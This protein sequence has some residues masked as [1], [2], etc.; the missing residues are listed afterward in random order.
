MKRKFAVLRVAAL[1]TLASCGGLPVSNAQYSVGYAPGEV[2]PNNAVPTF[3]MGN[4][5]S[6]PQPEFAAAVVDAMQGNTSDPATFV[7]SNNSSGVYRVIM[8]FGSGTFTGGALCAQPPR[9]QGMSGTGPSAS[10]PLAATL[11]RGDSFLAYAHGTVDGSGGPSSPA[12]RR[13]VGQF[14]R[15]LFPVQNPER[16]VNC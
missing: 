13:G 4:P 11:C 8:L 9:A 7:A 1:L 5:F 10:L 16:C 15:L 2:V 12:F 6:I 3:V 14:T